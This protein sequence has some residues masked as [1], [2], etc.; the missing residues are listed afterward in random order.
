MINIINIVLYNVQLINIYMLIIAH[1]PKIGNNGIVVMMFINLYITFF[2]FIS[3][4]Q[5]MFK[6][7][8]NIHVYKNEYLYICVCVCSL[9]IP[10]RLDEC[11]N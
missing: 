11:K 3:T 2:I 4:F 5:N 6:S 9:R 10:Q 1:F 8:Y 7:I